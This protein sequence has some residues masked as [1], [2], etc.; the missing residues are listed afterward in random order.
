MH[1]A[2]KH[3]KVCILAGQSSMKG[4]AL[5]RLLD[6]LATDAKTKDL[7][8]NLRQDDKWLVRDDVFIRGVVHRGLVWV[9][10]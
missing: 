8:A 9:R 2:D 10:L 1:T 4:R 7:V 3:V 6:C 5:N